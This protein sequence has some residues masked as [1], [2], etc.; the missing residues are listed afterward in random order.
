[1]ALR[2]LFTIPVPREP[3][4]PNGGTVSVSQPEP[5]VYLVTITCAPDNRLTSGS[6]GAIIEALDRLAALTGSGTSEGLRL[7]P[8]V[9]VTTSGIP[10]FYSNGLDLSSAFSDPTF[11]PS[12]LYRLFSTLL[13]YP[14]PTVALMNGHAFAGGLM[15]A[16]HHDYRVMNPSKGYACINE[17]EFGV[18]LKAAMSSIFRLKLTAA[19]YRQ[20]V[21]EAHRFGGPDALQNGIVDATGDLQ[22]VLVKLIG[23]KKL[24]EKAEPRGKVK[25]MGYGVLGMLRSEMYRESLDLLSAEGHQREEQR[26]RRMMGVVTAKL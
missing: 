8:G 5:Q 25:G 3:A 1:M 15:L 11:L 6:C 12:K 2:E 20:L 17:L 10:K 19:V 9:V 22:T 23:E 18:P 14:M 24:K 4:I 7:K 21:L 13:T 16:M 26:E